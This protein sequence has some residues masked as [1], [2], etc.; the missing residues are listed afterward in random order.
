MHKPDV[1]FLSVADN[2]S[3]LGKLIN[4]IHE[5]YAKGQ[6]VLVRVP[7]EKAAAFL[8]EHLWRSP[9][10]SFLPHEVTHEKSDEAVIITTAD[11]NLNEAPILVHLCPEPSAMPLRFQLI[12][13]LKDETL[14]ERLEASRLRARDYQTRGF[15]LEIR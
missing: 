4:T 13:D 9:P 15:S 5:H 1:V 6:R 11:R 12:Y 10:E 2:K 8:D 7:D 3:K 14:L